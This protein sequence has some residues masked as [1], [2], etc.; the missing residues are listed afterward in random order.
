MVSVVGWVLATQVSCTPDGWRLREAPQA[1]PP[2]F[3]PDY[4]PLLAST[5]PV[6]APATQW[7]VK[8]KFVKV[9]VP[10]GS[11]SSSEKLW[12]HLDEEAVGAQKRR[13]LMRNGFRVGV[14]KSGSWPP[15]KA[16]LNAAGPDEIVSGEYLLNPLRAMPIKLSNRSIDQTV[17]HFRPDATLVGAFFPRSTN[18]WLLR[19][20]IDP[21]R[22][23]VVLLEF[24]PE[25][26][27]Q[28]EGFEWRRTEEGLRQVPIYR[29][30]VGHEL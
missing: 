28:Q 22:P 7:V 21:E 10:L 16:I 15:I 3:Q 24:T 11:L 2:A 4:N 27:Q 9:Q 19:H 29:G 14:G 12:N 18:Y 5:A 23:E 17:W 6:A 26:R 25:V 20:G 1:G 8:C 13:V 30:W